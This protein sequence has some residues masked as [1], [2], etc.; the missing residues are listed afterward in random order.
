MANKAGMEVLDRTLSDHR[1]NLRPMGG[2]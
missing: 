2:T 1:D